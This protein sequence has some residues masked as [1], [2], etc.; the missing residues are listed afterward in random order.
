MPLFVVVPITMAGVVEDPIDVVRLVRVVDE[1]A[2]LC[3]PVNAFPASVRATVALVDGN[4]IVVLSV[5][6]NVSEWLNVSVLPLAPV[7]V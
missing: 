1:G 3:A 2:I 5:P 7:N 4:V 6:A